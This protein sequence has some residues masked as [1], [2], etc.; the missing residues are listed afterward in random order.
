MTGTTKR[1]IT[2]ERH[3]ITIIR[4]SG[5][6][7]FLFCEDCQTESL[8]FTLE[9]LAGFLQIGL[10]EICQ[11]IELSRFHLINGKGFALVCGNSLEEKTSLEKK[12]KELR[13]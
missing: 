11:H 2:I 3:S 10:G 1:Q 9:Q 7:R 4:I 12:N 13:K 5:K 6:S 8:A